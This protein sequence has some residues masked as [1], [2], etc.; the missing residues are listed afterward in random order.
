M[1]RSKTLIDDAGKRLVA[2]WKQRAATV[3]EQRRRVRDALDALKVEVREPLT[4]WEREEE[5]RL[6]ILHKRINEIRAWDISI[7]NANTSEGARKVQERIAAISVDPAEFG[8]MAADAHAALHQISMAVEARVSVLEAQE[9]AARELEAARAQARAA[10][11]EAARIRAEAAAAIARER[12]AREALERAERER[13]AAAQRAER[14][15]ARRAADE[16]EARQ[17]TAVQRQA[18]IDR[19]AA[20]DAAPQ[21]GLQDIQDVAT[22]SASDT[23]VSRQIKATNELIAAGASHDV[24]VGILV[25]LFAGR[26]PALVALACEVQS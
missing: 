5:Q 1:A 11:E 4:T 3:D 26:L 7:R 24:A 12:E 6:A 14:E 20:A 15:A 23:M 9:A 21:P 18:E 19:A 13:I 8:P 17:R 22:M 25:A 2:G 16:E 10:E